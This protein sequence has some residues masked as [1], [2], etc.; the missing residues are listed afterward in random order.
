[1]G[2]KGLTKTITKYSPDSIIHVCASSEVFGRVPKEKLP[3]NEECSFHPASPYAIAS[4]FACGSMVSF[5]PLLGLHFILAIVF[6]YIIRGN[7]VAALLGTIVGNPVPL[8]I[9]GPV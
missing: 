2:I 4:G 8:T 5:T 1:M 7:F 9:R 3:I 6:A